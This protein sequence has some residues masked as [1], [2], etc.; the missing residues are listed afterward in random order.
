MQT[1]HKPSKDNITAQAAIAVKAIFARYDTDHSGHL[2]FSELV[3]F[4]TELGKQEE[5]TIEE[6]NPEEMAKQMTTVGDANSDN[7]ISPQ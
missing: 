5:L 7:K 4:F 6:W 2:E 3:N 1:E